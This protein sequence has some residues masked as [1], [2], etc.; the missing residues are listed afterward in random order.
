MKKTLASL[1][2][3]GLF[4]TACGGAA[5]KPSASTK[6]SDQLLDN[7]IFTEATN[8]G[9]LARCKD[10]LDGT[11]K[12][13]CEQVIN[14]KNATNAAIADLDKSKCSKVSDE[15][16]KK[17]CETQIDVKIEIRDADA[18][19]LSLSQNAIDKGDASLCDKLSD[20]GQKG[21]CRYNI[22]APQA[23]QKKDPSICEGIGLKN[24]IDE[25][26]DS[27]KKINK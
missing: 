13:S 11:L 25:C 15:R 17:D 3:T 1:L 20:E 2:L 14:D 22:I 19:Q 21:S 26:K 9:N 8:G 18:K 24:M 7:N 6:P 5:T 23:I 10:I 12:A 16:Y 4:L 27:L